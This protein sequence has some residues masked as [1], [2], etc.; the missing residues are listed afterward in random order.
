MVSEFHKLLR[1]DLT[2][3]RSMKGE[4]ARPSLGRSHAALEVVVEGPRADIQGD[5][6]GYVNPGKH[7]MSVAPKDP[8]Y[9][10]AHRLP[11][12]FG[13]TGS[14]ELWSLSVLELPDDLEYHPSSNTHGV[15]SPARRMT[16]H[17]YEELLYST[18]LSWQSVV[19]LPQRDTL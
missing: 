19:A 3:Y 11:K 17:A 15:I 13:G 8:L 10:P 6:E 14:Y 1:V 9:L 16:L 4:S 7:G 5:R 12:A 18:R 2:L